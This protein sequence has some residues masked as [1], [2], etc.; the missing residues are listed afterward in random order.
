MIAVRT[1]GAATIE[2][3]PA[4]DLEAEINALAPNDELVL[5]G[6]TYTKTD[7][8]GIDLVGRSDA[9]ILIRAKDGE[10]PH[11]H[12]PDAGQNLV[13]IDNAEWVTL[14]G[15]EWSGGSAGIRIVRAR[16]LTIE[17][18]EVHDTGDVAIRANDTGSVYE[19]LRIIANHIHD[20]NDTGEGM[21][22]G[23]NSNG[24]QVK[25][26]LI[27]GNHVHHTN[28]GTVVQGDGIE[29]KE[30]SFNNVIRDNVIHDTNYPCI[31]TYSTAGNGGPNVIERNLLWGCGD[32][33]IQSAA[34]AI[35]RNN[36]IL[37]AASDGIAMQPHQSGS[38]ANLQVLHNTV[39]DPDGDAVSLRDRTGTVVIANN[40][41]YVNGGSALYV[42]GGT[43]TLTVAGNVA[44][45]GLSGHSGGVDT[46]G[47][48]ATDF[49]DA[50]FSGAVPMDVFPGPGSKLIAAGD[51]AYVTADD[52]NGTPRGGI[53]D[54]GAYRY[55]AAGNPGWVLAA[56]LK[57]FD[58]SPPLPVDGGP[59]PD[60]SPSADGG[61][62]PDG[63]M[64]GD[65]IG[66]TD[67][68]TADGTGGDASAVG[69]DST[70]TTTRPGLAAA[71]C[72]CGSATGLPL[73]ALS[74]L[75]RR[76]RRPER[77]HSGRSTSATVPQ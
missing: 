23:C 32:H 69:D 53:A 44:Q 29:L 41:L 40:A 28:G 62:A 49:V 39:I 6:G 11:I 74:L 66:S 75:A 36:I 13:D 70:T 34:D 42:S 56:A 20:T 45:G 33:G 65:P 63:A 14:R 47:A 57:P 76:R 77:G 37:S 51:A 5:Q 27:A 7:R 38:P 58:G 43:S 10:H 9:P 12:R 25:D 2:I 46:T 61:P 17:S 55:D 35:I 64:A 3:G 54:A 26:S 52:F 68:A 67:G 31:L 73:A 16:F 60:S 50:D 19:G 72:A 48:I 59:S 71:G 1:L 24:C 21:Y 8:F 4:D 15:I 18:C 30:G 22:L